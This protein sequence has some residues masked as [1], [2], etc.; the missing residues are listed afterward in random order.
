[1][2]WLRVTIMAHSRFI[3]ITRLAIPLTRTRTT[4]PRMRMAIPHTALAIHGHF[5]RSASAL[6]RMV[7]S[8]A[9]LTR[10]MVGGTPIITAV[11]ATMAAAPSAEVITGAVDI[12]GMAR[13]LCPMAASMAAPDRS[14]AGGEQSLSPV[15]RVVFEVAGALAVIRLPSVAVAA[16]ADS[17]LTAVA[18]VAEPSA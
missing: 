11:A 15:P 9:T 5:A 7:V 4:I 1:M 2:P 12:T 6:T 13:T 14:P 3:R 8:A 17:V 10:R 16:A 18:E